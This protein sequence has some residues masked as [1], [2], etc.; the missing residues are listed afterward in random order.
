MPFK[1][2]VFP[3]TNSHFPS[4]HIMK[5]QPQ[6]CRLEALIFFSKN[7]SFVNIKS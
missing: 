3:Y 6:I 1:S 4:F 5:E 7:R 2:K